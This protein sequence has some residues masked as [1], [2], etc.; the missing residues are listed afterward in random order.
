M[1]PPKKDREARREEGR[2]WESRDD[3]LEVVLRIKRKGTIIHEAIVRDQQ[4]EVVA[5]FPSG[6]INL[7]ETGSMPLQSYIEGINKILEERKRE[8][9][10]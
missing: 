4:V 3:K 10:N 5:Y 9:R 1:V 6:E 8:D 2:R 7:H